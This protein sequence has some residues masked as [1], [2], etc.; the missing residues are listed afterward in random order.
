MH[1]QNR[2]KTI[3]IHYI[4]DTSH[5]ESGSRNNHHGRYSGNGL[6]RHPGGIYSDWLQS[7]WGNLNGMERYF[8]INQGVVTIKEHG[9]YYI[10]AQVIQFIILIFLFQL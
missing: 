1:Q 8:T 10:Y 4:G 2:F 3:A 9:L 6:I 5:Y 7:N